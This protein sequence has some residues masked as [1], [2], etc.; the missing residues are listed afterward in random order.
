MIY[1]ELKKFTKEYVKDLQDRKQ[2]FNECIYSEDVEE[3]M[4]TAIN[5]TLQYVQKE[6]ETYLTLNTEIAKLEYEYEEK[7][8]CQF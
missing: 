2:I 6:R 1:N 8:L 4:F 5:K 7:Q 3:A